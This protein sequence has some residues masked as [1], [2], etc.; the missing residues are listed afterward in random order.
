MALLLGIT[1]ESLYNHKRIEEWKIWPVL[2]TFWDS[3]KELIGILA[4]AKKIGRP[5]F[6]QLKSLTIRDQLALQLTGYTQAHSEGVDGLQKQPLR[7]R[8]FSK[9]K[10]MSQNTRNLNDVITCR[11][12]PHSV[13]DFTI[14]CR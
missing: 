5:L 9:I 14:I 6:D 13:P 4:P 12:S 10:A 8:I 2:D 3:K 11:H 7:F 1:T